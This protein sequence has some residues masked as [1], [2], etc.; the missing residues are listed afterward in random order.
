M[1]KASDPV[2]EFL[3]EHGIAAPVSVFDIE[4]DP[5][6]SSISRAVD[7]LEAYGLIERP[8]DYNTHFQITD[9][10][11]EYLEGDVDATNLERDDVGDA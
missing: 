5:S 7:D 8:P 4:L 11:R 9:L 1:N 2:L 10:G 3:D 6:R